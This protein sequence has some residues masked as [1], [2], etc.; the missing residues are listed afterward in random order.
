MSKRVKSIKRKAH[1]SAP[2]K[3]TSNLKVLLAPFLVIAGIVTLLTFTLLPKTSVLSS[4]IASDGV[5]NI[6]S[7][8]SQSIRLYPSNVVKNASGSL[9]VDVVEYK[10][11][12]GGKDRV[13]FRLNGVTQGLVPGR[14][15]QLELCN[16]ITGNCV[17][18][19]GGTNADS[20]GK[21]SF[22]NI[23]L[24]SVSSS[25]YKFN[26]RDVPSAGEVPADSCALGDA[27]LSATFNYI[28]TYQ[29][30]ASGSSVELTTQCFVYGHDWMN[31]GHIDAQVNF[32]NTL[33]PSSWVTY[34][35]REASNSNGMI[36]LISQ[37]PGTRSIKGMKFHGNIG[38]AF[39]Q[40][41]DSKKIVLK[42]STTYVLEVWDGDFRSSYPTNA[43]PLETKTVSTGVCNIPVAL[44]TPT[45]TIL[46]PTKFP[47]VTPTPSAQLPDLVAGAFRVSP[48][49]QLAGKP[50]NV[51]FLITN[52]GAVASRAYYSYSS[53]AGG[54]STPGEGNT[55][56]NYTV[57][58]PGGS[59]VSSYN[60]TFPTAGEKYMTIVLDPNN[61]IKESNE[62]NNKVAVNVSITKTY[63]LT[64]TPTPSKSLDKTPTPTSTKTCKASLQYVTTSS[65]CNTGKTSGTSKAMSFGCSDGYV[66]KVTSE[67]CLSIGAW[68]NSALIQCA[69]RTT[70]CK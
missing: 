49:Q 67:I 17:A 7:L 64:V 5:E 14:A 44:P 52:K 54:Y 19:P 50:V 16:A 18:Q 53:Q 47:T 51:R 21:I 10:E 15:Y 69:N 55:C 30:T 1:R 24:D 22:S 65:A 6:P 41:K 42:G 28:T 58:Q 23:L 33:K 40:F 46:P 62:T 3:K 31:K 8:F 37:A 4:K 60:F 29:S 57:L 13:M 35:L 32:N 36:R 20:T 2:R 45:P 66:G 26:V 61:Q 38:D 56:A 9:T 39:E 43:T 48:S 68:Y 70:T 63:S 27:C 34:T 12:I 11:W 59:C 25:S